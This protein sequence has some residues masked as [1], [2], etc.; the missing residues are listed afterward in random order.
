MGF[1]KLFLIFCKIKHG[2][3]SSQGAKQS[4]IRFFLNIIKP[5]LYF[6]SWRPLELPFIGC[7][8]AC[9]GR[10]YL[11]LHFQLQRK[12]E[13]V[14]QVPGSLCRKGVLHKAFLALLWCGGGGSLAHTGEVLANKEPP[15]IHLN[16]IDTLTI[17]STPLQQLR[18]AERGKLPVAVRAVFPV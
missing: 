6:N 11:S 4:R 2:H 14:Q 16:P 12:T 3:Y 8:T 1:F 17:Y 5:G 10:G 7:S 18:F 9:R 15:L 13:Q